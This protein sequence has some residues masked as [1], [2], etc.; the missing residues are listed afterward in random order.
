MGDVKGTLPREVMVGKEKVIWYILELDEPLGGLG[1]L[2]ETFMIRSRWEGHEL[3]EPEETSAFV[4]RDV[5]DEIDEDY[6]ISSK[7]LITW[8]TART[9]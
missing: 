2:F 6:E 5:S 3:G 8:V 9:I 4:L 7:D 1:E